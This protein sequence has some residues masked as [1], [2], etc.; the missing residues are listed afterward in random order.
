MIIFAY[1]YSEPLL[2]SDLEVSMNNVKIERVYH[3]IGGRNELEKLLKSCEQITPNYLLIRRLEELGDTS[4]IVKDNYKKLTQ[5]GTKIIVLDT[6]KFKN[7]EK[8]ECLE[9]IIEIDINDPKILE[10]ISKNQ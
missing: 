4:E 9:H 10:N 7:I 8:V 3:D 6:H 5:L 1:F 2:E